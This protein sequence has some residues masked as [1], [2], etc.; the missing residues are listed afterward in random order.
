ME[1][2]SQETPISHLPITEIGPIEKSRNQMIM[3]REEIKEL[4][5]PPLVR[6][7]E[8]L[9]DKNIR[10]LSSSANRKDVGTG[11]YIILDYD[12]MSSENQEVAQEMEE[13]IDYDGMQALKLK[14]PIGDDETLFEEVEKS[15]L[16]MSDKF[17]KQE[18][19]WI[20]SYT[21]QQLRE[22]YAYDPEDTSVGVKDFEDTGFYYDPEEKLFYMSE[23]H[24]KKATEEV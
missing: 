24:Y 17:K 5:E 6:A 11:A 23:E 4:V 21:L 7:C 18:A 14:M 2:G 16:E 19:S 12:S 13:V 9:W 3:G 20:P 10:T 22:I 1:P 15:A 8:Q